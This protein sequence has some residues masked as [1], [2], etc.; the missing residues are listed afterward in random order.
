MTDNNRFLCREMSL[1]AFNRR[2]LAQAQDPN[3][4]LL[5]RLRFL[6]IVSSNL[7]E[8]FEV[9]IAGLKRESKLYPYALLDC[10]KT[11]EETIAVVSK[12]ARNLINEQYALF[13]DVLQPELAKEGI[14]FYRRRS[15]TEAQREWVSQYFDRELLP[16][17]TPIGLDPSHPFP[18]LLNKSLNFA[19]ELDGNDA[20]GRPSSMA[21]VQAPRILPRVVKMPS[22]I[23]QGDDGFVFLS[24]ILHANVHK[25]FLGMTVKGCH[26]FRLTRDSDLSVESD[27][28]Q[29]D[30]LRTAIQSELHYREYGDGVRL[31]VADLCPTHIYDFLLAQF[32]LSANELYRVKGPVNLI[33]LNA[34]PDLVDRPELKFPS[35]T[36]SSLSKQTKI[37]SILDYVRQAPILLHHPYQSFDPVVQMISEAAHDPSVLAIKM[38]IYRTGSRS[39]LVNALMQ[40][41]LSGKQVTVVVE[42]MARF[43]EANNVNWAQQLE[44]AGAH[45]VY[46]VFGYKVHAKMVLIIR[47]EQ[48]LLKRYAHLGTGN[49][50]QGTSRIYTDFGLI[51][52]DEQITDDVNTLF[53]EI[54]GLGRPVKLNKLYQSPFT[55]HQEILAHIKQETRNVQAGRTGRIIAKMNSL[56]ETVVIEAL[57]EASQAGVQIDLIIRGMCTLRPGVEGLSEN[58]RVRSIVG[59]QLE[60]SR[61]YYFYNNGAENTY[62]SSADWM[63]RN[64][65]LRIETATPIESPEL[66]ARVIEESLTMALKDNTKAWEMQP[67]GS[68]QQIVP[69]ENEVPFSLQNALWEKYGQTL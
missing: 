60:H 56:V 40:A 66:K 69:T 11:A 20:F 14:H 31:E 2:V 18:R 59:R 62:I 35:V 27:R 9:R 7:D 12:E 26:Q 41:A 68:Y 38:T 50:H 15:W 8:F 63:G 39:E 65:F 48:G 10:G 53:M 33:R 5:E 32:K 44:D 17:L 34:I 3:T 37:H 51:T 64:F 6:C 28:E 54:T 24:S 1:L 42:L 45:V 57:Y 19:V 67:D 49:Y 25:L 43:D 21:I 29:L 23:C 52:T 13:N 55:L 61:V 16:I 36:P 46:G 22:D 47:R 30:N 58:I 4:P